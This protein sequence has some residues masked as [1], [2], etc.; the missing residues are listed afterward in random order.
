MTSCAPSGAT[1]PRRTNRSNTL[2]ARC[3]LINRSFL[4]SKCAWILC[5]SLGKWVHGDEACKQRAAESFIAL[6]MA[7][8]LTFVLSF[9][10]ILQSA[11]RASFARSRDLILFRHQHP[12]SIL[13]ISWKWAKCF[14]CALV[15]TSVYAQ[16]SNMKD[17]ANF[18]V[19][20]TNVRFL[21]R[22]TQNLSKKVSFSSGAGPFC[23]HFRVLTPPKIPLFS[24]VMRGG[25]EGL[26][27]GFRMW[28]FLGDKTGE[29]IGIAWDN[30]PDKSRKRQTNER[31]SSSLGIDGFR[32]C[33]SAW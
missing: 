19:K 27:Q 8:C 23:P 26:Q 11:L 3:F 33:F 18:Q 20:S 17:R 9:S 21:L 13:R 31:P 7:V 5:V 32:A 15:R 28:V 10:F 12:E 4:A 16:L 1:P 29:S 6:A 24:P 14:A 25:R 30:M 22:L 2:H